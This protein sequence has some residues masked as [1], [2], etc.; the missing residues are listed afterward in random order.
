MVPED[1]GSLAVDPFH[2][3]SVI[4][5]DCLYLV[6]DF[7]IGMTTC[8]EARVHS[9]DADLQKTIANEYTRRRFGLGNGEA[10]FTPLLRIQW[11][12]LLRESKNDL[13]EARVNFTC[14][15]KLTFKL[16]MA[17]CLTP[18]CNIDGTY[19]GFEGYIL[20]QF[21]YE[22]FNSCRRMTVL[23]L[24]FMQVSPWGDGRVWGHGRGFSSNEDGDGPMRLDL[25]RPLQRP[26]QNP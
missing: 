12:D 5:R 24:P 21:C 11:R 6:Q 26:L 4:F 2:R 23:R 17:L 13:Y 1:C 14:A 16:A 20:P 8:L 22:N 18:V 19:M 10:V 25:S 3:C 9:A 7:L 15:K